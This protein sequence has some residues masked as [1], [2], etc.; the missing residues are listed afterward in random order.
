MAVG[1][2]GPLA[3]GEQFLRME[4]EVTA[5]LAARMPVGQI[6]VEAMAALIQQAEAEGFVVTQ[7]P[8]VIRLRR[9]AYPGDNAWMD[10]IAAGKLASG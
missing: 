3:P 4:A 7:G 10:V 6:E 1:H 8:Q 5:G 9:P 2:V